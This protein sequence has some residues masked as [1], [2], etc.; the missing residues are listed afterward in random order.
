MARLAAL[1]A[2]GLLAGA[3]T[4]F[5]SAPPPPCPEVVQVEGASNI[6]K[7]VDGPGRDL[8]DVLFEGGINDATGLCEYDVDDETGAG[9]LAVEMTVALDLGRGPANRDRRAQVGYF[10]AITD[11]ERNILNKQNFQGSVEFPG[12][13]TKL[14]WLDEPVY[15]SIPLK[16][17]QTGRDFLIFVG[18][19]VSEEE[20]RFNRE[21][22]RNRRR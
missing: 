10:I 20:L 19:D 12:N 4:V 8:I 14:V 18:F 2:A 22:I 7:F 3:C 13:K 21:R 17:G 1:A 15:L 16:G 9:T 11:T 5:E 6:T